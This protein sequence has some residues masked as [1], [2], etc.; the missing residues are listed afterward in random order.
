[1]AHR[2]V[3]SKLAEADL[4]K[5]IDYI[6]RDNPRVAQRFGRQLIEAARALGVAPGAGVTCKARRGVRFTV[7]YPYLI[8][9]RVDEAQ[10]VVEILRFW[11]GARSP[12]KMRLG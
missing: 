9:Y 4:G 7:L 5:I 1:M 3:L 2:V 8:F 10:G 6:A 11:H 12:R